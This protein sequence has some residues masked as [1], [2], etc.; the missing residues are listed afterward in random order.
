[1][2]L[3]KLLT[4]QDLHTLQHAHMVPDLPGIEGRLTFMHKMN[5]YVHSVLE[6]QIRLY[7]L[8][9]RHLKDLLDCIGILSTDKLPPMLFPP[10][11]LENI[12]SNAIDMVCRTH[13][14]Y[15]LA[16]GHITEYYDMTLG[17]FGI[18]IEGNMVVAFPI[19]VKDHSDKPK[20]LYELE[21][22]KV[23]IPDQNPEANSFSEVQYGKPYI[24][25]NADFYIQLHI[26][27]LRM[28]KTIRHVYYCEELFLIKHRTHPTCESAIFYKAPPTTVYSICTFIF[29]QCYGAAQYFRWWQPHTVGQSKGSQE[30]YMLPQSQ[31]GYAFSPISLCISQQIPAL[32]LLTP[33]WHNALSQVLSLM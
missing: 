8:M 1:M 12:T 21:T 9:L 27:E 33:I 17:T 25:V 6:R 23:P 29:L 5:L 14:E 20:T 19:F 7:E 22:V 13:P 2:S 3:E 10:T 28:C 30:S 31:S 4:G 24:A 18:N 11:V 16:V 26:Q 15:E 32:S